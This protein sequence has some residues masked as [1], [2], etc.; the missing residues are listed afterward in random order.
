MTS[1]SVN[2]ILFLGDKASPLLRWIE[3]Q[4][5]SVFQTTGKITPEYI[6][7]NDI[8]LLVSYG[9]RHILRKNILELL[10]DRAINLHI[11]YLPWN[12]GS[13]PNLW[14]MLDNS[15][16]GVTIHMIDE[17]IDTGD[18]L[19]QREIDFKL[20]DHTLRSSYDLLQREIQQ[21]FID[22]WDAIKDRRIH[23]VKQLIEGSCHYK[24]D[25]K[26][27]KD[28]LLKDFGWDIPLITLLK[29]YRELKNE[30]YE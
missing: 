17:G 9:Y 15:P 24:N 30:E 23:P 22:N 29:N 14:S 25:F 10:H 7:S 12:K 18:I 19:F 26:H 3:S 1:T 16:K 13:D 4:G 8:E 6:I 20:E 27:I 2:N 5:E 11:S 21:L 28:R